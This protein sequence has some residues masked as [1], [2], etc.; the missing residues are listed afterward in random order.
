MKGTFV[1]K[2]RPCFVWT[3]IFLVVGMS[4]AR[5]VTEPAVKSPAS[6]FLSVSKNV[7]WARHSELYAFIH[8]VTPGFIAC[9][10]LWGKQRFILGSFAYKEFTVLRVINMSSIPCHLIS[11]FSALIMVLLHTYYQLLP[12]N[13]PPQPLNT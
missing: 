2:W 12:Q 8:S 3:S 6:G 5:I 4:R 10:A 9:Y 13:Q 1:S 11:F 7:N